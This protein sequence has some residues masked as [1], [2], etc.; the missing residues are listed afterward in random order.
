MQAGYDTIAVGSGLEA[1]AAAKR[2]TF[3]VIVL[4]VRLPDMDGPEVLA[5]LRESDPDAPCLVISGNSHFEDAI[6]CLRNGA[7]DYVRKPFDLETVVRAVDRV[8]A[9]THLKVDAAL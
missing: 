9:S 4:D 8:L 3:D 7:T 2:D 5:A 1:V 6:R